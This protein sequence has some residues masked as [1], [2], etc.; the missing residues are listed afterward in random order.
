MPTMCTTQRAV[1]STLGRGLAH[2]V[3]RLAIRVPASC[4]VKTT[5]YV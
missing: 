2:D 5:D 3:R 4:F 1:V